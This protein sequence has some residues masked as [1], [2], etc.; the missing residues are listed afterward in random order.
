MEAKKPDFCPNWVTFNDIEYWNVKED[1]YWCYECPM[2]GALLDYQE[3]NCHD[4]NQ[5]I[6]WEGLPPDPSTKK[7][8]KHETLWA[9]K[10][11]EAIRM[12][13][14]KPCPFCGREVR[15][16][17]VSE[18]GFKCDIWVI[19]HEEKEPICFLWH[20]KGYMGKKKDIIK[21]WNQ[22]NGETIR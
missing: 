4:C 15:L 22:R 17:N 1:G 12:S 20:S 2:C 7:E 18:V 8:E 6:E 19:V 5:L 3:E 10:Q 11:E 13:E 9:E 21:L 14:L 16:V